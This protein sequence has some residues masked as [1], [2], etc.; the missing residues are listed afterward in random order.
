MRISRRWIIK[1][2]SHILGAVAMSLL[3]SV[4]WEVA[5][6]CALLVMAVEFRRITEES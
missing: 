5:L 4:G 3:I 6:G 2:L 1:G